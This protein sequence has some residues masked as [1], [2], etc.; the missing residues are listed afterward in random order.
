MS[1]VPAYSVIAGSESL[2]YL[3]MCLLHEVVLLITKSL[4]GLKMEPMNW[5][6]C[7]F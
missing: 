1:L 3:L 6:L 4:P 7:L 5:L 2:L